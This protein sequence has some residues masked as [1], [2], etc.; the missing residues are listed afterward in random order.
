VKPRNLQQLWKSWLT[1]VAVVWLLADGA[2]AINQF[3]LLHT[4]QHKPAKFPDAALVADSA[5]NLYGTTSN[6]INNCGTPQHCGVVFKLTQ[7]SG[8]KWVYTILHVFK[9]PDGGTLFGSLIF[10][11]AGN[12]FG[13][14]L[15]GGAYNEGTVFE[16]SPAGNQWNEKVLH[17]FGASNDLSLPFAAVTFDAN[18]NLYGTAAGGG[19]N[20]SGG[21][22]ELTPSGNGWGEQIIHH[23][24]GPDGSGPTCDLLWDSAGNLYGTTLNGGTSNWCVVIELTP[25]SGGTWTESV[26][27]QFTGAS[28]GASPPAGLI[29]DAAGNLYGTT[30]ECTHK[31]YGTVFQ[32]TPSM[33]KWTFAVIHAFKAPEDGASPSGGLVSDANGNFYGTTTQGGRNGE[34]TVFKLSPSGGQWKET[35]LHSFDAFGGK[36]GNSP[37]GGLIFGPMGNLYGTTDGGGAAGWGVVFSLAP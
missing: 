24:T 28:D 3:K 37:F 1:A 35:L 23:F 15:Q 14:T 16:L 7:A 32:L 31:C 2:Q 33:G 29:F 17:S 5:G 8:G 11:S 6:G 25:S 9:G 20:D 19:T 4:F 12:L 36:G 13:T 27:Y 10:D 30:Q 22:F 34:G 18:G 26:L 21:V